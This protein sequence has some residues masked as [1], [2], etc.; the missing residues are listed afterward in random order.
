M[1]SSGSEVRPRSGHLRALLLVGLGVLVA[2]LAL[3]GGFERL[4]VPSPQP[5]PPAMQ[6]RS[7]VRPPP[8][9]PLAPA[10]PALVDAPAPA[11]TALVPRPRPAPVQRVAATQAATQAPSAVGR[12]DS[13]EEP[14]LNPAPALAAAVAAVSRAA[15]AAAPPAAPESAGAVPAPAQFSVPEP[16][17]AAEWPVYA[18]R[19]PPSITLRYQLMRG[20]LTG[21]GEL[22][23]QLDGGRYRLQLDGAVLGVNVLSQTSEGAIDAAGVAPQRFTDQRLRR[24]P[25]AANFQREAG[26]ITFSGPSLELPL[27]PG[28]QDRLSWMIQLAAVVEADPLRW[29]DASQAI[30]LQVVG[31]RGDAATWV[32]HGVGP[33]TLQLPE[34]SVRTLHFR[35]DPRGP[36][37]TTVD[38]WLDPQRHHLPVRALQRNGGDGEAFE[39]RL[40][41]AVPGP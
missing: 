28:A 5:D 1:L 27:A 20:A 22:R 15:S 32:F 12:I 14:T 37:E 2:H 17:R 7:I 13:A 39:L 31:A 6:V 21:S 23:W 4:A 30:T 9:L 11:A 41:E 40:R 34:G 38:V 33:A 36:Y 29:S 18:T 8:A 24:A 35:R 10:T 25:Q 3:L 16:A 26:K 19:L